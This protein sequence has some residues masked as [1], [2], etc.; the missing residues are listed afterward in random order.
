MDGSEM[1]K[2]WNG[3]KMNECMDAPDHGCMDAVL[4]EYTQSC[5]F[6]T[7]PSIIPGW[8]TSYNIKS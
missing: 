2:C 7:T 8:L 3:L 4:H 5:N 1:L 6:P